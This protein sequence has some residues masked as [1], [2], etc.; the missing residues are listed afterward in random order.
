[1]LG[2]GVDLTLAHASVEQRDVHGSVE[3]KCHRGDAFPSSQT[4]MALVVLSGLVA[5]VNC[6]T[7]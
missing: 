4:Q 7:A 2:S 3:Q 5:H 1:M 6:C